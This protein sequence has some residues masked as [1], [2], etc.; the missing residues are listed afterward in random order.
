[1]SELIA[2]DDLTW[3][4]ADKLHGIGGDPKALVALALLDPRRAARW[5]V[6][7]RDDA[8]AIRLRARAQQAATAIAEAFITDPEVMPPTV[9]LRFLARFGHLL[10]ADAAVEFAAQA[11]AH[12]TP[13]ELAD[14]VR[15]ARG[16]APHAVGLLRV[17]VDL[18][19]AGQENAHAHALLTELGR[20]DAS[21]SNVR[22]VHTARRR[23][24]ESGDPTLRIALL[25][26]FTIDPLVP[27]LDL[28]CRSLR[29]EP[30][31]YVAP[32]NTWDREMFGEG[33]GLARHDAQLVFLSVALDDLLPELAGALSAAECAS[34]GAAAVDRI[35][36][37]ASRFLSWSSATLVVHGL[38]STY[39]DPLGAAAGRNA[40]GRSEVIAELNGRLAAGLRRLPRAYLLDTP[41]VLVRRRQ[42]ALES[43]KMRHLASM[44]LGEEVLE[45]VAR[46]YARFVAPVAG[47]TRKC[48]VLD[49]DNTLWGGIVGEDGPHGIRLGDTSPGSEFREFQRFLQSLTARGMLLALNSKNNAVD[50]LEV[51]RSHEA[52]VLREDAFSAVRINWETKT[53][54]IAGIAQEL[55][56]GLDAFVFV[57]DNEKERALMRQTYPQVLT[58]ELPRDPA[59]YRETLESLPELQVLSITEEDQSRTRMYVERRQRETLRVE[60]QTVEEY[61]HSLDMVVET[62]EAS[63]RTISRIHQLFQR[64]NQFNLTARRY[65]AGVLATRMSEPA[66]RVYGTRVND[67]F[68][69]HGLVAAAVVQRVPGAWKIES[70]V[71]SCRV[72]GYGVETALLARIAADARESGAER[73]I[74]EFI[75]SAKNAPARD[76]YERNAFERTAS[77]NDIMQWQCDLATRAPVAPAWISSTSPAHGS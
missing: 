62:D 60:S 2:I 43:P 32:F 44:R 74:G 26:S 22:F 11:G 5:M 27:Y 73:L 50:A 1:M 57:D 20:A 34:R 29:I 48:I 13:S 23:L 72:I 65:D 19:L 53:S 37:A 58:P 31:V 51:I 76:F 41:D 64:T 36:D 46:A 25:S 66:W 77:E 24:P 18:A 10:P 54:N 71:M 52:M 39:R 6:E 59:L 70:L 68:G 63:E 38:H 75:P 30:S 67:R 12:T 42:G 61:L 45:D 49:L 9:A 21:L 14:A 40:P 69:D 8:P 47:R 16:R 28:Q 33:S 56:L 3:Q 4:A 7:A 15:S 17:A 55:N 35:L